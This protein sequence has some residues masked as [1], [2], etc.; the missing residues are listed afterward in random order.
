MDDSLTKKLFILNKNLFSHYILMV[1]IKLTLNFIT[2][3]EII[4]ESTNN[5]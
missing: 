2:D 4:K 5:F 3:N 1:T